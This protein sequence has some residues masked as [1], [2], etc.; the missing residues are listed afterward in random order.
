MHAERFAAGVTAN[1]RK[2]DRVCFVRGVLEDL[3]IYTT[4][5]AARAYVV[6]MVNDILSNVALSL[7]S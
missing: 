4:A 1:Q 3:Y 6:P 5:S 2:T 7:R